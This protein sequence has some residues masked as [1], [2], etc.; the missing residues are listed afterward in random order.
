MKK[1][2]SI[3]LIMIMA[4]LAVSNASA[5]REDI[6][7][8]LTNVCKKDSNN[9][10]QG[11]SNWFIPAGDGEDEIGYFA[12][13]CDSTGPE[14]FAVDG[15]D[16][17]IL[18][19]VK[20]R[21]LQFS[22]AGCNVFPLDPC[23]H[24]IQF[25]IGEQH[26]YVADE[27]EPKLFVFDKEWRFERTVP[28][29]NSASEQGFYMFDKEKDGMLRILT[30]DMTYYSFNI[31]NNLWTKEYSVDVDNLSDNKTYSFNGYTFEFDSGKDTVTRFLSAD[32]ENG[33]LIVI[34]YE[35]HPGSKTIDINTSVC[36]YDHN[37]ELVGYSTIDYS[38]A[39]CFPLYDVYVAKD[40]T[41][42]VMTCIE[43]GVEVRPLVFEKERPSF[44]L[45][46]VIIDVEVN[47]R[48]MN[49]LTS[50]SRTDVRS[51]AMAAK[52]LTWTLTE[53][54]NTIPSGSGVILPSHI[55]SAEIGDTITSIPYCDGGMH[56][57]TTDF[58][59]D[60]NAGYTTGNIGDYYYL[61]CG[62]DCSGYVSYT[63]GLS[64][65]H[66]TGILIA[67]GYS[68]QSSLNN[69]KSMDFLV[70]Y[71]VS[72]KP[73]HAILFDKVTAAG[74][75]KVFECTTSTYNCVIFREKTGSS[76]S[77]Y[78]HR[79]PYYCGH[80]G[81]CSFSSDYKS[82]S[83]T[84][85]HYCIHGCGEKTAVESHSWAPYGTKYKCSVCGKVVYNIPSNS[86]VVIE[87]S[88]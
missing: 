26:N 18:D 81:T 78:A 68:G 65:H 83:Y 6:R 29:P 32:I 38:K 49:P 73:N 51:R 30:D 50:Y 25:L 82:D 19:A 72:G 48:S 22:K 69:M 41:V 53:G 31:G 42:Y 58:L 37:G 36:K 17:F 46:N 74:M 11:L 66:G 64:S 23:S 8:D 52:T 47:T 59:N 60:K 20:G 39:F 57:S 88:E 54:N 1:I 43:E 56:D 24:P 84:H 86:V 67:D 79:T 80:T 62:L 33:N 76:L 87:G 45:N 15:E 40:S 9:R 13:D 3:I 2:L 16:L 63:Y 28:I 27:A 5:S 34:V 70:R 35:S 14:A 44:N 21:L 77:D 75:I 4:L 85:W 55:A 12:D 71:N 61:T 10:E 7:G